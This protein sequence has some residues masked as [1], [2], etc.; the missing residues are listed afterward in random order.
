MRGVE[1]HEGC[2]RRSSEAVADQPE[3]SMRGIEGRSRL[4]GMPSELGSRSDSRAESRGGAGGGSAHSA[5]RPRRVV[6]R[7][8]LRAGRT[9]P[10]GGRDQLI[11]T[12]RV[13][14]HSLDGAGGGC[15]VAMPA[16]GCFGRVLPSAFH[17]DV[18]LR[19]WRAGR[20]GRGT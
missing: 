2:A 10:W 16:G 6:P 14:A 5:L 9:N 7:G 11:A 18:G 1:R 17:V 20:G 15:C 13:S 8:A 19:A 3:R 4:E 12:G